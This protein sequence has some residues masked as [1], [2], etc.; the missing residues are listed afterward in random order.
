[1]TRTTQ[2]SCVTVAGKY[3]RYRTVIPEGNENVLSVE[4]TKLLEVLKR[5]SVCADQRSSIIKVSLS[6][7]EMNLTAQDLEMQ[8][9]ATESLECDYDGDDMEIGFKAPF[10]IETVSSM[11][12][13]SIE[14]RFK[15]PRKAILLQ[16]SAEERKDE[17][18]EA[19]LM[20]VLVG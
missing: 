12:A 20:P 11:D 19:V 2:L 4:R 7:N 1:M 16:P 6:F 15:E 5:M 13:G 18:F 3:P 8:T 9:F 10:F 14:I 17:P